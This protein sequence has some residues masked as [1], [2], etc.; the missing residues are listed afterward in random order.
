MSITSEITRLQNAKNSLKNSINAKT[1]SSHKI[2]NETIDEY[3]DF[4]DSISGG[5]TP[6]GTI[7]ITQNGSYNVTDYA[8]ASVSVGDS[9]FAPPYIRF[10]SYGGTTLSLVNLDTSNITN[11]SSMF[12]SCGS[13][14][15]IE[16]LSDCDFTNVTTMYSMFAACPK[17]AGD[18]TLNTEAVTSTSYM[19]QSA[20]TNQSGGDIRVDF[21]TSSVTTAGYMFNSAGHSSKILDISNLDL[22]HLTSA[23]SMFAGCKCKQ[24]ISPIINNQ[25]KIDISKLFHSSSFLEVDLSN[26]HIKPQSMQN[27][28]II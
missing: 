8:T 19:F 11:A 16:G 6:T 13:L 12:G 27:I 15:S 10:S 7:N 14:V 26:W 5:V 21:D 28:L 18:I 1:D 20:F 3:S 22:S 9:I 4:V 23:Q 17:L 24:L 2:T 25:N